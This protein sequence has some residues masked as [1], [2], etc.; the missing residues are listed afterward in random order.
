MSGD[1]LV[2]EYL[3]KRLEQLGVKSILGVPGDF[4]LALLD[5]IEK[6]GDEKFRWVGNT[7]E[8]NGAYAADG[9]A[10]V[11][12][13]SAIVTTFGVGEL[14]AINGVAG[15]YAEHVPVVHIVGM[16]STK[17]Q[18][19]G[20]L[21]HHTL[22]DGDFR[23]FMDMFKKVS[24]Y[25]IMIDNGNDAAEKIDEALSICYKKARPVYIG[26]PSDAGYFKASSS[27]LGKRL[28]LEEDTNDP[29][30]E[31]EV[32]NHISEMVVNAKKPVILIDACAVRHRVV[33]EVHELI[34]LTHF[35]T[36]VT[37][38]GKSAIDETSQ[39]FDGVYVGSISDPEVKDR[40][41]S[42]DLL[43]SIGALKSD[44]NTGSFSY[45]LSQ[46]NAV[47]FHSDHMRIRYALYP[48]V[49]MKYILRKL[50]KVLD[51]SMCH[52]KAAPTI[53]YNIKPKH[54]EGYSSNEI[55]H[56]WFWPKFSEFLKPRDVLITE[57]GTANFGVLDCRFPKDVTA[58]SQVLWG[59][60]GYSVGAMF[61]AVLAV[62]DSK[63]PDRRTI[64]VVGDGS[65][66]LTITEISTCIRHNLK[67]IIFIINNDGYT[68]ERLIHGL[69]ASYN[70]INTKWGY[71][72]IPK[73]FGAAENHFRTYCVKTPTDVE[74]LFSDKEFANA[75]VI[76]V[77]ELV[78]PMLDAPRVLVEQAKL[79]SKINKQ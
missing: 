56:C 26:I 53:G 2:G 38:M 70:E 22:G 65:L 7:N 74:K 52:S 64:L 48:N 69:H 29:A 79:T 54:A 28:K 23:T 27:N 18:D 49:A 40:I 61:G 44:F 8:L 71:Q 73:F 42:T 68:I 67:P 57:T 9:Y 51:A 35:P 41:E 32:I 62:H 20:A 50:L 5:L 76:Q 45:H 12:G 59:S 10:R 43:L 21:L 39:F 30:V 13:L 31:Q 25:S 1:I 17:V 33:P 55:T 47:E 15:S 75:D 24:A 63:E 66:Q 46:K 19:T 36:Y 72:Q 77:V 37:P 11:N 3:F 60:I 14:S 4:N 16:P 34:K 6:V 58:I 78:M